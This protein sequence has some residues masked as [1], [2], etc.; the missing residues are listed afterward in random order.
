VIGVMTVTVAATVAGNVG[1]DSDGVIATAVDERTDTSVASPLEPCVD[2]GAALALERDRSALEGT[3]GI[4]EGRLHHVLGVLM[5]P[6]RALDE[7]D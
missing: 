5:V 2:A 1:I 6:Q 7:S 4:Q 3:L